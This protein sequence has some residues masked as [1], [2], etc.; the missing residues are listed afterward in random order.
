MSILHMIWMFCRSI[1]LYPY[2]FAGYPPHSLSQKW[3]E[4]LEN[5]EN[6]F[7]TIISPKLSITDPTNEDYHVQ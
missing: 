7:R 6:I 3:Q 2:I 1:Q 5:Y 4:V